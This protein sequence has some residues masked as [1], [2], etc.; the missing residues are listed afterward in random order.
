MPLHLNSVSN[1]DQTNNILFEYLLGDG[2]NK[3]ES[4]IASADG[5]IIHATVPMNDLISRKQIGKYVVT[6]KIDQESKALE[7]LDIDIALDGGDTTDVK[8]LE[9]YPDSSESNEYYEIET[10]RGGQRLQVETVNRNAVKHEILN[11]SQAVKA[12]VFPFNLSVYRDMDD[13]NT[14]FGLKNLKVGKTDLIVSGLSDTFAA[15]GFAVNSTVKP[16]DRCSFIIGTVTSVQDVR[17]SIGKKDICFVIAN[18]VSALG[19]IPVAMSR[20]VFDLD[21]L[22]VGSSVAMLADIKIDFAIG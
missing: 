1:D 7:V 11:T 10:L 8:F 13:L 17:T 21:N 4:I 3:E 5:S 19:E 9:R 14:A 18:I 2:L 16:D 15:P 12:S 6:I 22:A 20:D